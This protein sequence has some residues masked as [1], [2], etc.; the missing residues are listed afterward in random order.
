[1]RDGYADQRYVFFLLGVAVHLALA[2]LFVRRAARAFHLTMV[3][4]D[5]R[6]ARS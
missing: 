2:A 4:E 6:K 5:R 3:R 1:V